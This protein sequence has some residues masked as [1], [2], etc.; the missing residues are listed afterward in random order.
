[1]RTGCILPFSWPWMP[2]WAS[3]SRLRMKTCRIASCA[4]AMRRGWTCLVISFP[5]AHVR[6]LPDQVLPAVHR[7]HLTGDIRCVEK[8][9]H[10]VADIL[11]LGAAAEQ[12]GLALALE[13]GRRL[14][15]V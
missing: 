12:R 8:I 7:E 15:L 13:I 3:S 1:M 2:I 4:S 6:R 9:A 10:G 14:P 5:H 11:R